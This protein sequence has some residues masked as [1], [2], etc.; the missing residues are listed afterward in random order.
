[1]CARVQLAHEVQLRYRGA[2][3]KERK[4]SDSERQNEMKV[5]RGDA[6]GAI[7]DWCCGE[8]RDARAWRTM[9]P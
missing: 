9:A 6:T 1:M 3:R 5:R 4:M 2:E 8:D 7:I